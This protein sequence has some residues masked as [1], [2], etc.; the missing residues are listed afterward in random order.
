MNPSGLEPLTIRLSSECSTTEL[1]ILYFLYLLYNIYIVYIYSSYTI[2]NSYLFILF[3]H[4]YMNSEYSFGI[5]LP[6]VLCVYYSIMHN[7]YILNDSITFFMNVVQK[8]QTF[9]D[10]YVFFSNHFY[11]YKLL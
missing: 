4:F 3:L 8:I 6:L 7:I 9:S 11:P 5:H 1:W 2:F 10:S